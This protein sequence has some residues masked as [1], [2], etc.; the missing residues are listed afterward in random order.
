[1]QIVVAYDLLTKHTERWSD[2]ALRLGRFERLHATFNVVGGDNMKVVILCGGAGTR[3]REE[4]EFRPKPM[5][6]IGSRPILWHIMKMYSAYGFRDFILCLGYKGGII[7]DYFL[8]YEALNCDFTIELGN[9][10]NVTLHNGHEEMN[11]R[12]TLADTGEVAQKGARLKRIEK[13]VDDEIFMMTYGDGVSDIDLGKLVEF[14]LSHGKL[15]TVTGINPVSRFGELKTQ[16]NKVVKFLEKEEFGKSFVSGGFFVFNRRVFD[17][18]TD[19]DMCDL[20]I[21]PLERIAMKENSWCTSIKGFGP[22]WTQ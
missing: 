10:K 20:E 6:N 21:G 9:G 15:V 14:H 13:Y 4:T 3:L 2:H 16:G 12:A 19:D 7:K 5:I 1:M 11:W 17:Y 18:L 8:N 22:V